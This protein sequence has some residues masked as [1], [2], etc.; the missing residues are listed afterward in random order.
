MS[1]SSS[2]QRL[3]ASQLFDGLLG[4]WTVSGNDSRL[5]MGH[6]V[7]QG[8]SEGCILSSRM[9]QSRTF[10]ITSSKTAPVSKASSQRSEGPE[11]G[12]QLS[13]FPASISGGKASSERP[14]QRR[15]IADSPSGCNL[16]VHHPSHCCCRNER[17]VFKARH[18]EAPMR[19]DS[20]SELPPK[21]AVTVSI[22]GEDLDNQLHTV[23]LFPTS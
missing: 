23:S 13:A 15:Q 21:L 5:A 12:N 22:F 11:K 16:T 10:G 18:D 6:V 3:C 8:V 7:Q 1:C 17:A 14:R 9:T 19:P 4:I 2:G 20:W